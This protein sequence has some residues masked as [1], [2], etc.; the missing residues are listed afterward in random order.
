M[1]VQLKGP[2]FTTGGGGFLPPEPLQE[3]PQTTAA[4]MGQ[5]NQAE[6]F[7]CVHRQSECIPKS[8]LCD[9]E[10]DCTDGSDEFTCNERDKRG[11][12]A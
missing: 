2:T 11:K 12:L 9:G 5:C 4:T 7:Q 3:R 10:F 1:T 8:L 6:Y